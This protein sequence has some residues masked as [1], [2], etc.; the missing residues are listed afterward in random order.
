VGEAKHHLDSIDTNDLSNLKRIQNYIRETGVE[1]FILAA[2]LRDLRQEEI[3]V[4]RE[5]ANRPPNTL[6]FRSSIEPVLP[7][8]L[9]EQDLSATHLAE[10]HPMRWAPGDGVVGLAKESCRRNLGM[11]TLENAFESGEFYF[12][13][14][15]S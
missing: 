4:M 8:V 13:P 9:T 5:F 1:C 15:W 3:D 10:Q 7:I 2:V 14:R 12:R 11:I 6:P